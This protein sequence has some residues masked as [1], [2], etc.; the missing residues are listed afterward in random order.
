[1]CE[2]VFIGRYDGTGKEIKKR[3]LFV[4]DVQNEYF[5][6]KLPVCY[7]Q[8]TLPNILSLIETAKLHDIPVVMI[9]HTLLNKNATAF[10]KGTDG[11]K[12][13]ESVKNIEPEL[14]VE[15]NYPSAFVGTDLQEWLE[16]NEIDTVVISGYMTQF[17]CDSTAKYAMHLGYNVE[18]MSDATATLGFENNAGKVSAEE[19]HRAILVHQAARFSYVLSAQEWIEKVGDNN[20]SKI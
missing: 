9:Q 8:N 19:L 20:G 18:F 10:L 14:Y 6:G 11:W 15:K 16:K 12:L 13:H 17:C 3:A 1:M 7:P 2:T 4:I 5:T